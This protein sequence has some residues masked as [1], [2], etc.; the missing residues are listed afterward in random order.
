MTFVLGTEKWSGFEECTVK[1]SSER[2]K[3]I[4]M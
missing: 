4:E 3:S 2:L 1:G